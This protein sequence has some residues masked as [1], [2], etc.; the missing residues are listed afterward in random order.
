MSDWN[1]FALLYCLI[2]DWL[3][4]L[5][6]GSMPVFAFGLSSWQGRLNCNWRHPRSSVLTDI[7]IWDFSA[8]DSHNNERAA[9]Q[10]VYFLLKTDTCFPHY[11]TIFKA[12]DIECSNSSV[13]SHD[14]IMRYM[15][16]VFCLNLMFS[17]SQ[18]FSC[19]SCYFCFLSHSS[20][21][22]LSITL[23]FWRAVLLRLGNMIS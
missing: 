14:L 12:T 2:S 11:K 13:S 4:D 10:H 7:P 3:N 23:L 1:S 8:L 5:Q 16:V 6:A 20:L 19:K 18:Y 21:N 9:C 22:C 17:W 15:R